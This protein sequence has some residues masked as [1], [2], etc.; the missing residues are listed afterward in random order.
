MRLTGSP[1]FPNVRTSE[2]DLENP[3]NVTHS[4]EN[5]NTELDWPEIDFT[6]T[7]NWTEKLQEQFLRIDHK[8]KSFL[9]NVSLVGEGINVEAIDCANAYRSRLL[10]IKRM[11]EEKAKM[12]PPPSRA[13][14]LQ[15]PR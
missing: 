6:K 12:Q 9:C 14:E 1:A 5:I 13:V 11:L 3:V 10:D 2:D 8:I 7:P 15:K 4:L